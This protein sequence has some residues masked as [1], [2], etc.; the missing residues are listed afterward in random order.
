MKVK[1]QSEVSH[2]RLLETPGLQPTR[3]LH[4]W[5]F[6]GK[7]TGVGCHAIAQSLENSSEAGVTRLLLVKRWLSIIWWT[8]DFSLAVIAEFQYKVTSFV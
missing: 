6:P 4:P 3:L 5:D 8:L 7:S 1:S 2:V